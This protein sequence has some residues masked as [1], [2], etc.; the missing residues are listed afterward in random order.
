MALD[1]QTAKLGLPIVFRNLVYR[2]RLALD[3]QTAKLT[4]SG[5]PPIAC[6]L[7]RLALDHQT[8]KLRRR[9]SSAQT[10]GCGWPSIT[11]PLNSEASGPHHRSWQTLRLALDHQTAKLMPDWSSTLDHMGCGWPS[12]TR[13][14]NWRSRDASRA[15]MYCCGWPSITRPLNFRAAHRVLTTQEPLRLA[16]DHQTAKL[17]NVS[18]ERL[19]V[20]LRLAL[21]H[22]TAKL[23]DRYSSGGRGFRC[24]WPSITRPLNS[25]FCQGPEIRAFFLVDRMRIPPLAHQNMT[26]WSGFLGL[27]S[28]FLP[29]KVRMFSYCLSVIWIM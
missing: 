6:V 9:I 12:I 24:G 10:W 26:N 18:T 27:G 28:R 4:L 16:L 2:L 29:L 3:H 21:D 17:W 23:G 5:S 19:H 11:R 8:A 15:K 1:H 25:T 14:L 7:L 13:P 20:R 22:Q